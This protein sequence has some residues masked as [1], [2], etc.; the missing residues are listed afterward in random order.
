M[1]FSVFAVEIGHTVG[2]FAEGCVGP[3]FEYGFRV[4]G[5]SLSLIG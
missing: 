4:H 5:V 3:Q 2:V 1:V